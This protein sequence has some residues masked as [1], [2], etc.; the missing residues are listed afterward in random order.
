MRRNVQGHT[1]SEVMMAGVLLGVVL[2][3]S[4]RLAWL[5]S[6]SKSSAEAQN[7]TFRQASIALERMQ[8]ECLH[9][10]EI[11]GPSNL[12]APA[13]ITLG[14]RLILRSR[15]GTAPSSQAVIAYYRDPVKEELV[16]A[17]YQVQFNRSVP[18]SQVVLDSPKVVASGVTSFMVY[19]I[20]PSERSSS[21]NLSLRMVVRS[22][23]ARRAS[24]LPL[25]TEVR[26]AR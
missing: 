18:S 2:T 21:Q 7:N 19:Q 13:E 3:V 24:G 12:S 16:R 5:A 4:G 17:T 23:E 14:N 26:L 9:T 15:S 22:K 10:Q 11:Y 6:R 20:D 8:R 25:A 1:L